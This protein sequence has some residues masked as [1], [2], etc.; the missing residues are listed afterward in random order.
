MNNAI[1]VYDSSGKTQ[2]SIKVDLPKKDVCPKTYSCAIQVLRQNWRQGTVGCKG[3]GDVSFSNKKPW[4]QKGT[5][6]ARA[7]TKA[8]PIWRSG[9]VTFGPSARV[10][11][12]K[13]LKKQR[14]LVFNNVFHDIYSK[15]NISCLD[16][17]VSGAK[18]SAKNAFNVLKAAG[19]HDKKVVLFAQHSD[20]AIAYSF[21]NLAN[22]KMMSFDEPNAYHLTN[23]SHWVVLKK[24]VS[25]FKDMVSKWN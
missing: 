9:G 3:R 24:D 25:S 5:G 1:Q 21:R 2:D 8:S 11:S 14:T 6:R 22:V 12:L 10:R 7:G 20:A 15:G 16:F 17:D 13:T 4:K 23:G 19:L 18:P